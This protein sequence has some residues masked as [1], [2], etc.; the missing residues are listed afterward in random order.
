MLLAWPALALAA[1]APVLTAWLPFWDG[2]ATP[3]IVLLM[4]SYHFSNLRHEARAP[5]AKV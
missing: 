2:P 5:R 4:G 1:A 3:V